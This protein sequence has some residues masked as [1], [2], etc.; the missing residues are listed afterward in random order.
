MDL[1]PFENIEITHDSCLSFRGSL[2]EIK[3]SKDS[4]RPVIFLF[5]PQQTLRRD[6]I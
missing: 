6:W 1:D 5:C 4:P 2:N 3:H